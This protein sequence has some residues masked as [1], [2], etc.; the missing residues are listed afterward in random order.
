MGAPVSKFPD[1]YLDGA[2]ALVDRWLAQR[3]RNT[4]PRYAEL[5]RQIQESGRRQRAEA[6]RHSGHPHIVYPARDPVHEEAVAWLLEHVAGGWRSYR[7]AVGAEY[8]FGCFREA[9]AF[10][11]R[12]S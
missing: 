11:M 1:N 10:R 12:W 7:S 9:V 5:L 6:F 4:A 8:A 2:Q 3:T